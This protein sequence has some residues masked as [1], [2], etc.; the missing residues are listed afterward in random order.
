MRTDRPEAEATHFLGV[1]CKR[2]EMGAAT[3]PFAYNVDFRDGTVQVRGGFKALFNTSNL[4]VR[5]IHELVDPANPDR[6]LLAVVYTHAAEPR[7]VFAL[8]D[9]RGQQ[10]FTHALDT[11]P[12]ALPYRFDAL[13]RWCPFG[14]RLLFTSAG[15]ALHSFDPS[16][17]DMVPTV[18]TATQPAVA[19]V[20]PYLTSIPR[21]GIAVEHLGR[22][23]L[24]G[25]RG[26]EWVEAER[27]IDTEQDY[28]PAEWVGD[29][30]TLL[31]SRSAVRFPRQVILL[32]DPMMPDR[33]RTTQ[34]FA[35]PSAEQVTGLASAHGVLLVMTH[36]GSWVLSG[37]NEDNFVLRPL[38]RGVG[39]VS[40]DTVV[41]GRG[42]VCWMAADGFY[43]WDG[44]SVVP[45]SDAIS[46][47]WGDGW[48]VRLPT[49]IGAAMQADA[50]GYPWRVALPL[51]RHASGVFDERH[52]RFIW[53]VPLS[54]RDELAGLQLVYTPASGKW[55]I[56][57]GLDATCWAA[58]FDG[59]RRRLVFGR[60]DGLVCTMYDDDQDTNAAREAVAIRWAFMLD[61]VRMGLQEQRAAGPLLVRQRVTG[62]GA[63]NLVPG[64]WVVEGERAVD[65]PIGEVVQAG[66]LVTGPHEER[67]P[68]DA[69][70]WTTGGAG[71]KWDTSQWHGEDVFTAKYNLAS[72]VSNSF[73]VGF[74][75]TARRGR[76]PEI[77][78]VSLV[79]NPKRG[80]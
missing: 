70:P 34:W 60:S 64:S 79:V 13:I 17:D 75:G 58:W 69:G 37:T 20:A 48:P 21:A 44:F 72:V 59:A 25:L 29:G 42:L 46:D 74:T 61:H 2:Y 73:R 52:Q 54:G 24:A 10:T 41:Q 5:G 26:D 62:R 11:T 4:S 16:A 14:K 23:A 76:R 32:S 27:T 63:D 43:S 71:A 51:W 78:E 28:L 47:L 18:V 57:G 3:L 31:T 80:T 6:R 38:V 36:T 56:W 40:Q 22:V 66:D 50:G 35:V 1:S 39:C 67:P 9:E 77:H 8:Y 45:I 12:A 53:S 15:G 68:V 19:S 49:A 7:L 65:L 55:A 33:W 30:T